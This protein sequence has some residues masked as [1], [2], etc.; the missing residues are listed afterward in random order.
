MHIFKSVEENSIFVILKLVSGRLV[1]IFTKNTFGKVASR[2]IIHMAHDPDCLDSTDSFPNGQN[3]RDSITLKTRIPD[4][5]FL[6]F[7]F[8]YLFSRRLYF[9]TYF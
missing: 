9:G 4:S 8:L 7:F 1:Y 6:P 5:V 3:I 2:A